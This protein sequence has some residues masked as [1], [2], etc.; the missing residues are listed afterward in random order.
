MARFDSRFGGADGI[1]LVG[2]QR[3]AVVERLVGEV[4]V[5]FGFVPLEQRGQAFR[6][7]PAIEYMTK[8]VGTA[9]IA[10]PDAALGG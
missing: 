6:G 5:R 7:V 8:I 2:A 3:E 1:L 10:K 4:F 9:Q